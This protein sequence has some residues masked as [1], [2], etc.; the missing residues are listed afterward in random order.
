MK[1]TRSVYLAFPIDLVNSDQRNRLH[2]V[3]EQIWKILEYQR[4][5]AYVPGG[6]AF[7]VSVNAT[8]IDFISRVNNAALDAADAVI[9]LYPEL[10]T[11]GVPM[12]I[13][14]ALSQ[15]K[16]VVVVTEAFNSW[17]LAGGN[18]LHVVRHFR[19]PDVDW[20]LEQWRTREARQTQPMYVSLNPGGQMPA[21]S[22]PG[23]AGYDLFVSEDVIIPAG[24]TVDVATGVSIELPVGF[25]GMIT[26]RSSTLRKHNLLVTTGVIDNGWR[27]QLYAGI[28]NLGDEDFPAK[29]GMRLAQFIPLPLSAAALSPAQVTQLSESDRGTSGFGSTGL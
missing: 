11:V 13:G 16:P 24:E 15:G 12:E 20:L 23:D 8:P 17:S 2:E 9:A 26:G 5:V 19:T 22:Y 7:Q 3:R 10:P 1:T 18:N 28:R 14:R 6:G 21:R 27:G 29:R 25:W 4:I